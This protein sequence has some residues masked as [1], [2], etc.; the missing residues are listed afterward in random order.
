MS[1]KHKIF[2]RL[3][4]PPVSLFLKFKFNYTHTKAKNLPEQYIVLSNHNTDW[5]PLLVASSFKKQMYFVASEHISRWKIAFKFVDFLFAPIMR[6]KGSV[7]SSTVLDVL[8][9]VRNGDNVCIFAEGA[10]SWDG[11]T[12]PIL[13]STGKMIKSA[14]CALVTYKLVGGYFI[15]P[16][17]STSNTRKGYFHGAPVNVYTK[18]QLASMSVDEIN[19]CINRDLFEDAYERQLK[20]NNRYKGKALAENLENLLFVCPKC[21]KIDTMH[22]KGDTV[23]CDSCDLSFT[24]DEYGML[25]SLPFKTI[26]ELYAW[27]KDEVLKIAKE[28]KSF[29]SADASLSTV[30]KHEETF[31]TKGAVTLSPSTLTINE[32]NIPFEDISELA[33]HGS[34]ALVFTA[35]GVYYE[36]IIP[37]DPNALKFQL[38]YEALKSI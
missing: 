30:A 10:R 23:Y 17:W 19:E 6:S 28:G 11:I 26:K 7:A 16:N 12:N 20:E 15:S 5:D 29:S 32:I 8:R 31:L 25:H 33:M 27:Q 18:E 13:P 14:K 37:D 3:L 1:K 2:W 24:Y 34:H 9:K 4:N 35:N 22:S 38:L 36:L 21:K